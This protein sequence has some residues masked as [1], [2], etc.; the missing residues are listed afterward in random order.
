M[1]YPHKIQKQ[2]HTTDLFY[3]FGVI[4]ATGSS[5]IIIG[6]RETPMR[7]PPDFG[8]FTDFTI[9]VLP[10]FWLVTLSSL[11]FVTSQALL[12]KSST[13]VQLQRLSC[14]S[15]PWIFRPDVGDKHINFKGWFPR[16]H[17]LGR[18]WKVRLKSHGWENHLP[19]FHVASCSHEM[20]YPRYPHL[21][22]PAH[23]KRVARRVSPSQ[24]PEGPSKQRWLRRVVMSPMKSIF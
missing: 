4:G 24:T 16:T 10:R 13:C 7:P 6:I 2:K 20:R 1:L 9:Q 23:L 22:G 15:A 18:C 5:W 12:R 11:W 14:K 21:H 8:H 17:V 19:P 3:F